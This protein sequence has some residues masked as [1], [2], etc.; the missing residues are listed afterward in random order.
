MADYYSQWTGVLYLSKITN[1]IKV[2]FEGYS[3]AQRVEATDSVCF[4]YVAYKSEAMEPDWVDL[5]LKLINVVDSSIQVDDEE[6]SSLLRA[7]GKHFKVESEALEALIKSIDFY[8]SPEFTVLFKLA[9]LFDDGHGLIGYQYEGANTCSRQLVDGF[10]GFGEFSGTHLRT[11]SSSHDVKKYEVINGL[12]HEEKLG[13]AAG[14]LCSMVVRTLNG[15]ADESQKR[16]V[17]ERLAALLMQ[18]QA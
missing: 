6:P 9:Q 11:W 13:E 12:L 16:E 4:T 5:L 14:V 18:Q 17:T 10:G 8:D 1:V 15:I 7:I 3:V 2:M